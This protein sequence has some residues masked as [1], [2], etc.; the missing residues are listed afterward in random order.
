MRRL[1]VDLLLIVAPFALLSMF[2]FLGESPRFGIAFAIVSLLSL[3]YVR[4]WRHFRTAEPEETQGP[5][6][7]PGDAAGLGKAGGPV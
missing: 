4:P 2:F 5:T 7:P 6:P 1:A 3:I